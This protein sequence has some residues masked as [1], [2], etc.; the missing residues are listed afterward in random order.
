MW[1]RRGLLCVWVSTSGSPWPRIDPAGYDIT[2]VETGGQL[3]CL[4][5]LDSIAA[6]YVRPDVRLAVAEH[7]LDVGRKCR[8]RVDVVPDLA[9]GEAEAHCEAKEVDQFLTGMADEMRAEDAVSG[10]VDNDLRPRHR[11]GIGLGREP[12]LHVVGVNVDRKA[13]L[14]G[15]GF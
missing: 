10:A 14:P 8:I 1:T 11:L 7:V 15:S 13:L 6:R 2:I 4:I 12:V 5:A 9:G 3:K